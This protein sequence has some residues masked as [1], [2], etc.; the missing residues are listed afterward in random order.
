MLCFGVLHRTLLGENENETGKGQGCCEGATRLSA[1][2]LCIRALQSNLYCKNELKTEFCRI[3]D[4]LLFLSNLPFLISRNH[5]Y[6]HEQ[7]KQILF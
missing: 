1:H 2:H 4:R 3:K 5:G 6:K 7:T